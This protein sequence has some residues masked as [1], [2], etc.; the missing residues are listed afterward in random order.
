M[1]LL[2]KARDWEW[3]V[4][5]GENE[6]TWGKK[7]EFFVSIPKSKIWT[8]LEKIKVKSNALDVIKE[9]RQAFAILVG[10]VQTPSKALAVALALT[11][12]D[13]TLRQLST[14]ETLRRLLIK[15]QIK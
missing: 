13:Q 1:I 9:D 7:I 2:L 4:F 12:P 8:G 6:S 10:K 14:K 15:N 11:E 3:K 5:I